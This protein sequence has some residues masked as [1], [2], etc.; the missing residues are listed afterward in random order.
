MGGKTTIE[1]PQ[2]SAQERALQ[3]EQVEML[4]LQKDAIQQQQSFAQM[5][6]PILFEQAGLKPVYGNQAKLE[7][8]QQQREQIV[9]QGN[10]PADPEALNSIQQQRDELGAQRDALP[11]GPQKQALTRKMQA[12]LQQREQLQGGNTS[13]Q[14]AAIDAQIAEAQQ[15]AGQVT[16]YEQ[17]QGPELTEADRLR[18]EIELKSLQRNV[19]ALKGDVPLDPGL[20]RD[21]DKRD[22]DLENQLRQQ[23]GDL[24]SSPAQEALQRGRDSRSIITD[25]ARRG[26]LTLAQ[27]LQ[28]NQTGINQGLIDNQF[29]RAGGALGLTNPFA[30]GQGA[31]GF[32]SAQQFG[33]FNRSLQADADKF[34][35]QQSSPLGSIL[36]GIAGAGIGAMTGGAGTAI[37]AQFG[38][39]LFGG[40]GGGGGGGGL[41]FNRQRFENRAIS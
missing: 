19:A 27:Q 35:A 28:G 40:G 38:A 4:Q 16:G 8:L 37:G 29:N 15:T 26:D 34:N 18:E 13:Q 17:Q 21:L 23:F 12:L 1:A 39:S 31:Q 5:I 30:F 11:D 7:Q 9:S 36:G 41:D 32:G 24:T 14:L 33:Q 20:L 25:Q 10:N 6:Q 3:A 22:Q 2:P